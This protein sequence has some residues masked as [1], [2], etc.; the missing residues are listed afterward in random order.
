MAQHRHCLFI[1][2]TWIIQ[3]ILL[4]HFSCQFF[5][6]SFFNFLSHT[7][8]LSSRTKKI[9]TMMIN[10]RQIKAPQNKRCLFS[11]IC[12]SNTIPRTWND[13]YW[14]FLIQPILIPFPHSSPN[15]CSTTKSHFNHH[16]GMG[17]CLLK[18]LQTLYYHVRVM[19]SI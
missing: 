8:F 5:F 10:P 9:A 1:V 2:H 18:K 19:I 11:K 12:L 6:V 3:S 17:L 7:F 15:G 13:N 16:H 4:G 14:L